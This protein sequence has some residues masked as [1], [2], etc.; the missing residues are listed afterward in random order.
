MSHAQDALV[1]RFLSQT[2]PA[3]CL[4]DLAELVLDMAS[5]IVERSSLL[6]AIL[7]GTLP[8]PHQTSCTV[9]RKLLTVALSSSISNSSNLSS[10]TIPLS[11]N[12]F[13]MSRS[14]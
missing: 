10:R 1:C 2:C 8:F 13:H 6:P 4:A 11:A 12:A 9:R 5:V 14:L 3:S 7:P